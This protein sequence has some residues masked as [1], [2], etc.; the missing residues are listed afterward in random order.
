M[1]KIKKKGKIYSSNSAIISKEGPSSTTKAGLLKAGNKSVS[2]KI[3]LNEEQQIRFFEAIE[4]SPRNIPIL[5]K[6]LKE[7]LKENPK[8]S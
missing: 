5:R 3:S 6:S 7:H 4:G 2:M 8:V 1:A